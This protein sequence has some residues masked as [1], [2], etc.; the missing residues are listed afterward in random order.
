MFKSVLAAFAATTLAAS[1]VAAQNAN[2]VGPR[3]EVNGAINTNDNVDYGA[4]IGNDFG[5]GRN[6]IL[7]VEAN[8]N[9]SFDRN[10]EFGA[11]ARLGVA[12]HPNALVYG[13]VGYTNLRLP[14]DNLDGVSTAGGVEL[15]LNRNLFTGVEYRYT[16]FDRGYDRHG[17]AARLGFRF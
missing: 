16:N 7:G 11:A 9:N 5:L 8:T 14:G 10:R 2:F 4:A 13:K 1:P 12:V 3:V 6:A 17:V 15:R